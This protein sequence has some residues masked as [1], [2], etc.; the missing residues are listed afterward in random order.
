MHSIGNI[1]H[2]TKVVGAGVLAS[3]IGIANA[4]VNINGFASVGGGFYSGDKGSSSYEGFDED[5]F[6]GDPVN[7]IGLQFSTQIDEKVSATGQLLA[8]GS[9]DYNIEA[10]WAYVTYTARDNWD[11]RIGRLRSPF[12]PYS[13]F[14]DVGYAYPWITPPD[15]V[16]RFL[17]TTVEGIDTLYRSNLGDWDYTFQAYY[18][19]LTDET[20]IS[21]EEVDLDLQDFAGVNIVFNRDWL[22]LRASYNVADFTIESPA[23]L[24]TGLLTPLRGAGF[25]ASADAL[26]MVDEEGV[27]WGLSA[28]IDYND[29]L[30]NTEYTELGVKDQSVISDDKAYYIMLGRR[31]DELTVHATFSKQEDDPDTSVF[32]EIPNAGPTAALRAGAVGQVADSETEVIT[33]GLRYDFAAAT[34]FKVELSDIDF[35]ADDEDGTLVA[36][37][38]DTVF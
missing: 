20:V 17:F 16:Y 29:W 1:R 28:Q 13:D 30:I 5:T 35:K 27:F 12:F 2:L 9:N 10:E 26:E 19:R 11:V 38:I 23:A 3:S 36:F 37:A 33:L 31:F 21:G 22:T 4:E 24:E 6:S 34:S 7:K 25:N 15:Q 14:L 18:G 32:E 8:K